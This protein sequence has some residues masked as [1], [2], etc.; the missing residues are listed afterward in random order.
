MESIRRGD[1]SPSGGLSHEDT[2]ET[3]VSAG[4]I[5][6][7]AG[8]SR[9]LPPSL[10]TPVSSAPSPPDP[11][12]RRRRR[13]VA[14]L[15]GVAVVLL[16]GAGIGTWLAT[17][18][19]HPRRTSGVVV[20]TRTVEVTAGTMSVTVGASG[21]IQPAQIADLDFAVSGRVTAVDVAVGDMVTAGQVL[22]TVAPT[23]LEAQEAAAQQAL[24][25]DEA[26]LSADQSSGAGTS[27]V[28]SDEAQVASAQSQ[29][30]TAKKSLAG[31]ALTSTITGEVSTVD[32]TVGEQVSGS[33]GGGSSSSPTHLFG[34]GSGTSGSASSQVTVVTP[35]RFIVDCTVD[36]TEI[37]E[38]SDGDHVLVSQTGTSVTV[39]GTVTFVGL[40]PSGTGIPSY[41]V[42]V[43]LTGTP[44][45]VFAGTNAKLSFVVKQLG[46]ALEVPTPA[47]SYHG[48]Q[49]QVTVVRPGGSHQ[50]VD[51]TVGTTFNGETQVVKGLTS[52]ERVLERLETFRGGKPRRKSTTKTSPF[53]RRVVTGFA[54]APLKV[55]GG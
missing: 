36:D 30:T 55:P 38:L 8:S 54:G 17:R 15:T 40:V 6:P 27:E 47:V 53:G 39:P 49:A 48:G 7:P 52:G 10:G 1:G 16:A 14:V 12:R 3:P 51:V 11:A 50:V 20:V 28:A 31:A 25:A 26:K 2:Q 45:G 34:P 23:S 35:D 46:H 19:G 44:S 37:G 33:G 4:A 42:T 24:S 29:L 41:P 22:A 5:P 13:R 43:T 32:L 18:G 9:T 21:T